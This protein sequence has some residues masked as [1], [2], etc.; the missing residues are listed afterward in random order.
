MPEGPEIRRAADCLAEAVAGEPITRAMFAFPEL[1]PPFLCL[2][3]SGGN[4]MLVDVRDYT[5]LHVIGA[6]RRQ[7]PTRKQGQRQGQPCPRPGEAGKG[8][9][10]RPP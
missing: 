7:A 9:P 10:L 4:T 8:L 5:E 2:A 1:K 3:I 6:T